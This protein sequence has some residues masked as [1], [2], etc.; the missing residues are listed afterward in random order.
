MISSE[1]V[2]YFQFDSEGNMY[3]FRPGS[4]FSRPSIRVEPGFEFDECSQDS[5]FV[6]T[7]S[8]VPST[9]SDL[10][11]NIDGIISG[12]DSEIVEPSPKKGEL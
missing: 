9:G 4:G 11:G 12:L 8:D 2:Q 5:L 1:L 10:S 3:V 6:E 7:V